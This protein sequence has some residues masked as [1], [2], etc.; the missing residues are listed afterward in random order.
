MYSIASGRQHRTLE[1]SLQTEGAAGSHPDIS[2]T[3]V[4]YWFR[5]PSLPTDREMSKDWKGE[6]DRERVRVH[7]EGVLNVTLMNRAY[8]SSGWN[9][10]GIFLGLHALVC[11]DWYFTVRS[12]KSDERYHIFRLAHRGCYMWQSPITI[13]Q[14]CRCVV[15]LAPITANTHSWF[16]G[17]LKA[18][19]HLSHVSL[20]CGKKL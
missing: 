2:T 9:W 17:D 15:S 7:C 20:G 13:Y 16:T 4:L 6:R 11:V 19:V 18:P 1:S 10:K 14:N 3:P 5:C 12:V 8:F